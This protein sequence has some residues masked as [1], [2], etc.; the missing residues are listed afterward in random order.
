MMA[1]QSRPFAGSLVSVTGKGEVCVFD[2]TASERSGLDAIE[3]RTQEDCQFTQSVLVTSRPVPIIHSLENGFSA[4]SSL[5]CQVKMH[6]DG[7]R[8]NLNLQTGREGNENMAFFR[9]KRIH[10][11][12]IFQSASVEVN[13]VP[14]EVIIS[15]ST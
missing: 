2:S 13:F 11:S 4:D 7:A 15:S 10:N 8:F 12:T 14:I 6:E 9:L 3:K 1:T 5:F